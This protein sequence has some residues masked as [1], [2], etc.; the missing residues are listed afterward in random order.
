MRKLTITL[1][2]N[3][4][5]ALAHAGQ[6]AAHGLKTKRYR[7][8]TLNFEHGVSRLNESPSCP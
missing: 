8:E 6:Q 7:G 5:T 1:N 3:W 4:R 2:N